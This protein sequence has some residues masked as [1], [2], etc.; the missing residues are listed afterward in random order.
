MLCQLSA[1]KSKRGIFFGFQT[2]NPRASVARVEGEKNKFQS[3]LS[4]A[5]YNL[6]PGRQLYSVLECLHSP[7]TRFRCFSKG[8]DG[9]AAISTTG[10]KYSHHTS[11]TFISS[12]QSTPPGEGGKRDVKP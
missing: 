12:D 2:W 8:R 11:S 4:A 1:R 10:G 9:A 5:T 7:N 6:T 3:R